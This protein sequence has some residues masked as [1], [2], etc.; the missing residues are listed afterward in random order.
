MPKPW[1]T[2]E[3]CYRMIRLLN[4]GTEYFQALPQRPAPLPPAPEVHVPTISLPLNV[5]GDKD[6]GSLLQLW[7]KKLRKYFSP[8]EK[9]RLTPPAWVD[10]SKGSGKRYNE[11]KDML[12]ELDAQV[13]HAYKINNPV[14]SHCSS[15][16]CYL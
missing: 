15:S 11:R 5:T 14:R 8:L 16:P 7:E 3:L 1:M 6:L 9:E 12:L 4:E 2:P 13:C 10:G